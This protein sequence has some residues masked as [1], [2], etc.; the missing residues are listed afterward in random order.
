MELSQTPAADADCPMGESI[1][2]PCVRHSLRRLK[3]AEEHHEDLDTALVSDQAVAPPPQPQDAAVSAP[4]IP[5]LETDYQV[6]CG[7]A[8]SSFKLVPVN[9]EVRLLATSTA[10]PQAVRE[11]V[12]R[13]LE[14][15]GSV[16]YVEGLL[17]LSAVEQVEHPLLAP[18][19]VAITRIVDTD[20][21]K[22]R[23]GG[24]LMSWQ[25]SLAVSEEE[26]AED[27]ECEEGGVPSFKEWVLPSTATEGLWESLYYDSAIKLR[28][29]RYATSALLFAEHKVDPNLVSWNRV[30]L[31]HGPP[32]TG[33]TSLC[34]ALAHKL[35]VRFSHR[36]RAASLVEVNA[37]SLFSKW[38]SESGKQVSKLFSKIGELIEESDVLVFV[39]IDEIESLAA[40]RTASAGG[41]EPSD[42]VRAV[43]ALLTQLD[44]LKRFPNVMVLTTSNIT[45]AIDVAFA[46]IGPPTLA[47]R[48]EM[49]RS[50]LLALASAGILSDAAGTTVVC[51]ASSCSEIDIPCGVPMRLP[52]GGM[53]TLD[54][55]PSGAAESAALLASGALLEAADGCEGLSGRCLRKLPFLAHALHEGLPM[56]CALITYIGALR[57][58]AARE[59]GDR[60]ELHHR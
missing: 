39:L 37:H 35:A 43:N 9:V 29:L 47:A 23:I 12:H 6:V 21:A 51:D 36:Y 45:E 34:K 49:L 26:A 5:E 41:S 14:E 27:D 46:Y 7:E 30:V 13:L 10:N 4:D 32:G 18:I 24:L 59:L 31:L 16:T 50:S 20:P 53:M 44:A 38:F 60:D 48:Y 1:A 11:S 57:T 15:R 56:P 17:T 33:K 58:A 25:Y 52:G 42:A 28:L 54:D 55:E 2:E 8:E 22:F 3:A 19:Q 40:A